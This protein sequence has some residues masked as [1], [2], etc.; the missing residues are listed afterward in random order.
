MIGYT[1]DY[2][3]HVV[4]LAAVTLPKISMEPNTSGQL[5]ILSLSHLNPAKIGNGVM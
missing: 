4:M 1:Y 3:Y 5:V 2:V